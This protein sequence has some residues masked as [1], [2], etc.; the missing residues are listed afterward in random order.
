M[1]LYIGNKQIKKLNK[2]TE[3]IVELYKGDELI[4][5]DFEAKYGFKFTIDTTLTTTATPNPSNVTFTLPFLLNTSYFKGT[6]DVIVDWGDGTTDTKQAGVYGALTHTYSAPGEYQVTLIPNQFVNGEVKEGWLSAGLYSSS[7]GDYQKIKSIDSPFPIRGVLFRIGGQGSSPDYCY[8]SKPYSL[9]RGLMHLESVPD[10]LFD[11]VRVEKAPGFNVSTAYKDFFYTVFAYFGAFTS[12]SPIPLAKKLFAKFDLSDATAL[13]DTFH[14]IFSEAWVDKIPTG[15]FDVDAPLCLSCKG[16]FY[17]AF[18]KA[19]NVSFSSKIFS[20]KAPACTNFT[21]AFNSVFNQITTKD[22]T[23][24]VPEDVFDVDTSS[25]TTF[26]ETF[27][28]AFYQTMMNQ[29]TFPIPEK[30][31]WGFDLSH[32]TT[33]ENMFVNALTY[34]CQNSGSSVTVTIPEN[35]FNHLDTSNVQNFKGMFE[36]ALAYIGY[37]DTTTTTMPEKLFDIDTSSGTNF[38]RMFASTFNNTYRGNPSVAVPALFKY[39][40]TSH[41]LDF[42]S[43]FSQCFF[44][45]FYNGNHV[46]D[47]DIFDFDTSSGTNFQS[48]F[49]NAFGS[50]K[51]S[52]GK[53][54]ASMCTLDTTNGVNFSGMFSNT[55]S[56]GNVKLA[57]LTAGMFSF[58][59]SNGTNFNSMFSNTF[60]QCSFGGTSPLALPK[61]FNL[62]TSKGK[63]FVNMFN[64]LFGYIGYPNY[65]YSKLA[66]PSDFFGFLDISQ[67]TDLTQMFD[68]AFANALDEIPEGLFGSLVIPSG[69]T[70]TKM[71]SKTF[72]IDN[73]PGSGAWLTPLKDIF[74]GMTDF[75]WATAAN[76]SSVFEGTFRLTG[77]SR[78]TTLTGSAST[79]LQHFNFVP[80]ADTNMFENQTQLADY[81]TIDNNW[82]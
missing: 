27:K 50:V 18:N 8:S 33:V 40:D 63:T 52:G 56:W 64:N 76:A 82:K 24:T 73:P 14:S 55:F 38:S 4:F 10:N 9:L 77:V 62:N 3:K 70:I 69:A 25:G 16:I 34:I 42:S 31:F 19:K 68:H 65:Q 66:I 1:T 45:G 74:Y 49:S 5:E 43:M 75:S 59:T 54:P 32:A 81:A 48:M 80:N 15:L 6:C 11:N 72:V 35:L 71:F 39:L 22:N 21:Q 17:G 46:F 13:E 2:G 26:T 30:I 41:G 44:W 37:T 29:T 67:A 12:I 7:A 53:V 78:G 60:Y 47:D 51:I 23:I 61:I 57:E 20:L 79:I 58:D 28:Q 36:S